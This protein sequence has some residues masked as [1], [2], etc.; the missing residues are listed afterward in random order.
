MSVLTETYTG[1]AELVTLSSAGSYVLTADGGTGGGSTSGGVGGDG[2]MVSGTF[3]LTAGTVLEIVVGGAGA[4]GTAGGGGGGGGSFIFD[5]TTGKLLEAAGGGG[6]S[7]FLAGY[8]GG[9]GVITN[10]GASG[11]ISTMNAY[12]LLATDTNEGVG[13]GG[14]GG[15]GGS[16]GVDLIYA[17][18]GGGGGGVSGN[19]TNGVAV[20]GTRGVGDGGTGGNGGFL[21]PGAGGVGYGL[22]GNGGFGGGGGGGWTGGGGGGGYSGGGGGSYYGGGGG[23]SFVATNASA[24]V[25]TAAVNAAGNGGVVISPACFTAGTGIRTPGGDVAV[26]T[27]QAGDEVC[28]SDGGVARVTWLG[29]QSV[30]TRFGDPMRVL[31]VRVKAGALG[32]GVPGRDLLV[33]GEH[34]LFVDGI[35]AQ[36]GALVNGVSVVREHDVPEVFRYYHVELAAHALLVAENTPAESF[37]DNVDRG[38]FENWMGREAP[39]RIVEMEYPR[40]KAARQVPRA[41]RERLLAR[42]LALFGA[43]ERAA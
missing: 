17:A 8:L 39:V 35:L 30:S 11:V 10:A 33:S 38:V 43:R 32:E 27:L 40:A 6:G 1:V 41:M 22:S 18:N 42:G 9:G 31:P 24:P 23:G 16:G 36:A 21:L 34:A 7:S 20:A 4:V 29:V 19:G 5:E 25:L 2:A 26:E 3:A 28:L 37:V 13:M 12:P 14:V 15:S